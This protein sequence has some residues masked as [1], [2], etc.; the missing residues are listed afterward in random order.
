LAITNCKLQIDERCMPICNLQFAFRNLQWLVV[1][2]TIFLCSCETLAQRDAH[3]TDHATVTQEADPQGESPRPMVGALNASPALP[4]M[5]NGNAHPVKQ[6][7]YIP[8]SLPPTAWT[9]PTHHD[10]V[11]GTVHSYR[12][13]FCPHCQGRQPF[14]FSDDIHEG[15][16]WVPDGI[17][18]PWP[19]DEYICDG[20]D[21]NHDVYVKQDFTVVG[22]DPE[23]TIAHYDTVDG[24]TEVSASN[25]VCIYAPR[26]AAVRQITGPVLWEAH[27]RMAA[28]EKPVKLNVHEENRGPKT[29]VQPEQLVAQ[30]GLDQPQRFIDRTRGIGVEQ[31]LRLIL[32]ADAFLPHENLKLIQR[33][34]YDALEKA[35]LAERVAAAETWT[36]NQ[37][38]QVIID[39]KPAVEARGTA[40]P[41]ETVMYELEG[42]PCLRICKIADK[43]EAQLDEIIQ[44]TLRFDNLG[45]QTIGNVTIIDHLMPRL[46]FVEGSAESSVKADFKT[47]A[48]LPEESLILRWEIT[49]PL[50]VNQGGIIRFQARVR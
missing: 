29:A 40:T 25:C 50:K 22:L 45:D 23:D 27:E 9:G 15:L 6:A 13:N 14:E 46:E 20:S 42:R 34:E 44:F 31:T 49:E 39:G 33:G 24:R 17:S 32:A 5:P 16:S 47:E 38:V 11:H 28:I 12:Q 7:Q 2:P 3:S 26:F 10:H 19:K 8:Q 35:R 41:Q 21:L 30:V 43:S 37:A 36:L 48:K 4:Q 1:L 18:C